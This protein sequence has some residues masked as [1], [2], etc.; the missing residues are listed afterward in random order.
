MPR[1]KP[2]IP[3]VQISLKVTREFIKTIDAKRGAMSRA[4]YLAWV[5]TYAPNHDL[6]AMGLGD[7]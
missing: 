2:E 3:R 6:V 5:L 1:P 4:A 7:R